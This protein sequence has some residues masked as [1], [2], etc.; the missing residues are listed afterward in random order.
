M[1]KMKTWTRKTLILRIMMRTSG[2]MKSGLRMKKILR[3]MMKT[4]TKRRTRMKNLIGSNSCWYM[5][6]VK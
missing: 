2:T 5:A 1:N 3:S 6:M 4:W